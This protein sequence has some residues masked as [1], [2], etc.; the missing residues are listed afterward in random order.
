MIII[1][2]SRACQDCPGKWK[3]CRNV[4]TLVGVSTTFTCSDKVQSVPDQLTCNSFDPNLPGCTSYGARPLVCRTT[5]C[6][7]M[8]CYKDGTL[9]TLMQNEEQILAEGPCEGCGKK[10]CDHIVIDHDEVFVYCK[11]CFV[12]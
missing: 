4:G 11:D 9:Q 3:C 2:N 5:Y 8:D 12:I 6:Q 7:Y 1:Q 10:P